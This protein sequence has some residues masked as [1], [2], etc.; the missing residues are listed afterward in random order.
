MVLDANLF[1]GEIQPALTASWAQRSF[2][3]C[4]KL[5][6][7]L[8]NASR[9]FVQTYHIGQEESLLSQVQRGLPF[10]RHFWQ[11]LAGEALLCAASQIPEFP[12]T[13]QTLGHL[14]APATGCMDPF[15]QKHSAPIHQAHYGS[16][17]LEFGKKTY[18][19][20]HAGLNDVADVARIANYLTGIDAANWQGLD[21]ADLFPDE[22]TRAEE[23]DDARAW[24]PFLRDMYLSAAG[25]GELVVCEEL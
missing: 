17:F 6:S 7:I 21:L 8:E 14:L 10:D 1:H 4:R 19:P 24:F 13:P 20:E 15:V 18:R 23:L 2:D 9:T 11:F 12:I 5:A 3:P 22:E 25:R 16:R